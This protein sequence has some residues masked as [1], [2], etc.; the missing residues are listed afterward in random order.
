MEENQEVLIPADNIPIK[1]E[2]SL[3]LSIILL[4][5]AI[6]FTI[7]TIYFTIAI[8]L[9][10]RTGI[11]K[12]RLD[13]GFGDSFTGILFFI[14]Y[15]CCFVIGLIPVYFCIPLCVK[16]K[17][18]FKITAFCLLGINALKQI[19]LVLSLFLMKYLV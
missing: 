13:P 15:I 2:K 9:G 3:K 4:T 19:L 16:T 8:A 7:A 5:L 6:I 1:K 10:H 12:S 11:I 18:S 14:G 17:K